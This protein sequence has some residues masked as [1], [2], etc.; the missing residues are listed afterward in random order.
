[1]IV[2]GNSLE[3]RDWSLEKQEWYTGEFAARA[4]GITLAGV[5]DRLSEPLA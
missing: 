1:M 5:I 3:M 2:G 4:D